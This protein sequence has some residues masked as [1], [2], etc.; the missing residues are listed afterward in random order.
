MTR[1]VDKR[2]GPWLFPIPMESARDLCR[3]VDASPSP[4]HAAAAVVERLK[5]EALFAHVTLTTSE[6]S[7]IAAL[8]TRLIDD[9]IL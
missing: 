9:G 2:Q 8:A 1:D 4:W 7:P 6:R 5:G 3:F